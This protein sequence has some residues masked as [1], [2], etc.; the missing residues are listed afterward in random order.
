[1]IVEVTLHLVIK[2]LLSNNVYILYLSN[3]TMYPGG[4]VTYTI[5]VYMYVR[6]K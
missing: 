5:T 2:E 3:R 4:M 1:M 6:S